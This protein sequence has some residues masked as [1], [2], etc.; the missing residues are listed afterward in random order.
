M[1]RRRALPSSRAAAQSHDH[2]QPQGVTFGVL[3]SR[4]GVN[5]MFAGYARS[6]HGD[7]SSLRRRF[8]APFLASE[9]PGTQDQLISYLVQ[10]KYAVARF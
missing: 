9:H 2:K 7:L 3:G 8:E 6:T 5:M 4:H 1:R 10:R